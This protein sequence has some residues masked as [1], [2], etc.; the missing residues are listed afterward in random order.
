M[1]KLRIVTAL[2]ASLLSSAAVAAEDAGYADIS[3][4]IPLVA[5]IDV[6]NPGTTLRY[7]EPTDAGAGFSSQFTGANRSSTL[8]ISSN[9]PNSK[10]TAQTDTALPA[11]MKLTV[12]TEI[13]P[14]SVDAQVELNTPSTNPRQLT[15]IGLISTTQGSLKLGLAIDTGVFSATGGMIPH[16]TKTYKVIYTLTEN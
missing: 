15:P 9:M 8:A 2:L 10:L 6:S 3:F 13:P 11:G 7:T 1:K 5:L 4:T 16:G 12:E 14:L